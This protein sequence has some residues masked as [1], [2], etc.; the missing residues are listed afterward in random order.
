MLTKGAISDNQGMALTAIV[1]TLY[2]VMGG[3]VATA[4]TN[5]IHI[6]AI[7]FGNFPWR[8]LR[9]FLNRGD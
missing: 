5:L 4:Y 7:V 8:I 6:C 2:N 3:F 9:Y 1:F